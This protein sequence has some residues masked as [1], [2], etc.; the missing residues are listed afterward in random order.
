MNQQPTVS[1]I[2][3]ALTD[4]SIVYGIPGAAT[5]S[6]QKLFALRKAKTT[7]MPEEQKFR[8]R[9]DAMLDQEFPQ[10]RNYM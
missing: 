8:F 4:Y 3:E 1:Q 6:M 2:N 5:E 7:W 9:V 10:W